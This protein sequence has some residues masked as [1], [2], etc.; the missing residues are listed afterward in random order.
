MLIE[1]RE[2]GGGKYTNLEHCKQYLTSEFNYFGDRLLDEREQAQLYEIHKY[3]VSVSTETISP[4]SSRWWCLKYILILF[5]KSIRVIFAAELVC[6]SFSSLFLLSCFLFS[7]LMFQKVCCGSCASELWLI[8]FGAGDGGEL[9]LCLEYFWSWIQ[10]KGIPI[11]Y[12][13]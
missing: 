1:E 10:I 5:C 6:S 9:F 7:L 13:I 8:C 12:V 2:I 4:Y 3:I 11:N